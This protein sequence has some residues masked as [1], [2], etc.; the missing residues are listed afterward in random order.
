VSRPRPTGIRAPPPGSGV[1]PFS[2][3]SQ[4][5]PNP[6][7]NR[8]LRSPHVIRT[9]LVTTTL[10][11]TSPGPFYANDKGNHAY[12]ISCL[13]RPISS[14]RVKA[15]TSRNR[16]RMGRLSQTPRKLRASLRRG[17]RARP[18]KWPDLGPVDYSRR[19]T[20]GDCEANNLIR[21]CRLTGS[22]PQELGLP[23]RCTSRLRRS[24]RGT[25]YEPRNPC[26]SK[27]LPKRLK[28]SHC[29]GTPD[30][31]LRDNSP[32]VIYLSSS[33]QVP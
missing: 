17:R 3:N 28:F 23:R 21:P 33:I 24:H 32:S 27:F 6:S 16:Y 13:T 1:V 12:G 31:I 11:P 25:S 14:V 20:S 10:V 7:A 8:L 4:P 15:R 19:T 26:Q 29:G 18:E 22:T 5:A 2:S 9:G 30:Q